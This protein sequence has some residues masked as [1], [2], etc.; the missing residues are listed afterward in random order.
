MTTQTDH[1]EIRALVHR[2][3]RAL[4]ERR[5]TAG[6][7]RDLLTDDVR[8]E[9]PLGTSQGTD[10]VRA[11]EEALGRYDRTQH[12]ASGVILDTDAGT[13]WV[14]ASWNALMTHVHHDAT[15]QQRGADADPLFTVGGRFEAELRR[16]PNGWR[17]SRVA[18]RPIWTKGQPPL[19]VGAESA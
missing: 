11:T 15:L 16:T 6:W 17:F 9:T 18:V 4:D 10:A 8:M 5:F 2:L 7:A 19:G 14:T 3:F 12:I 1:A 13:E